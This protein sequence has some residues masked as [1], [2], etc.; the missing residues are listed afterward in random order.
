M[1]FD[2]WKQEFDQKSN[3]ICNGYRELNSHL[4]SLAKVENIANE[5]MDMVAAYL[6][7]KMKRMKA[8]IQQIMK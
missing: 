2:Q 1:T 8:E 3:N 5:D 7:I 4:E 6:E